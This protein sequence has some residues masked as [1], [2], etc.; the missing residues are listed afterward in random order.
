MPLKRKV[1]LELI[2]F[3]IQTLSVSAYRRVDRSQAN[4]VDCPEGFVCA[5]AP[6]DVYNSIGDG[7]SCACRD[8]FAGRITWSGPSANGSCIPADCDIDNSNGKPGLACRCLQGFAGE[9][10]WKGS[11]PNGSC[12]FDALQFFNVEGTFNYGAKAFKCCVNSKSKDAV[13][14][15]ITDP[16]AVP[17]ARPFGKFDGCGRMFGDSWHSATDGCIVKPSYLANVTGAPLGYFGIFE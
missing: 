14:Q 9:V 17:N 1:N 2:W 13:V 6:C 8:G 10:S 15:D 12:V 7:P 5:I 16:L 11:T 3:V 4:D